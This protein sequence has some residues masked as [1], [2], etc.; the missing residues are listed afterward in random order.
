MTATKIYEDNLYALFNYDESALSYSALCVFDLSKLE[1][2]NQII[3]DFLQGYSVIG[4]NDHLRS[5]AVNKKFI[6]VLSSSGKLF[7]S[8]TEDIL[9]TEVDTLPV[10]GPDSNVHMDI[11]GQHLLLSHETNFYLSDLNPPKPTLP[12]VTLK[13]IQTAKDHEEIFP[14]D[15]SYL[16]KSPET[17][18]TPTRGLFY[19]LCQPNQ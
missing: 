14:T 6:T 19:I 2:K 12:P 7:I 5:L 9:F 10:S 8:K 16:E 13:I 18:S 4:D 15:H 3:G 17:S 1:N 11:A